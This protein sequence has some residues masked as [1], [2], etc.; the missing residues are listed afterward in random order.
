MGTTSFSGPVASTGLMDYLG[1]G[2]STEPNPDY[3][4]DAAPSWFYQGVATP[5][6]RFFLQ[7]AKLNGYTGVQPM[8]MNSLG[9]EMVDAVPSAYGAAKIAALQHTT[10]GTAMTLV[11]AQAAGITPNVPIIPFTGAVNGGSVVTAALAL[12]FGFAFGTTT[13]ASKTVTVADS[14]QFFFGMPLVLPSALTST[15]PLLTYVTGL[16]SST[17]I[18]LNNAPGVSISGTCP[19]GMGNVWLS[20]PNGVQYPTAHMPY[21]A[22]GPGL[23]LDPRQA[24]ARGV[25]ITC[26]SASGTGGNVVVSGWDVYGQAMTETIA[27]APGTALTAYGKKAFKF[28]KSVT[29]A[30]TD[31]T[32]NY[33]VG[34]SDVFGFNLYA[35]RWELTSTAWASGFVTGG[36]GFLAGTAPASGDVRGT[37][38]TSAQGGGTG[39]GSTASNGAISGLVMTGNRLAMFQSLAVSDMLVATPFAPQTMLGATQT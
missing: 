38:Q 17:T 36:T 22:G 23:F 37:F 27:I 14:T 29:P 26:S 5:D 11:S 31:A 16:P 12:D 24:L 1:T 25:S 3:N 18:T 21:I 33:S 30:F 20:P 34:T 39:F 9:A 8:F 28:I 7:S 6:P 13:A 2:F 32:Y 15:T 10:S 4:P 35:R 19:I